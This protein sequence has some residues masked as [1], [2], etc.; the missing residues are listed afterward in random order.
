MNIFDFDRLDLAS[1]CEQ[2]FVLRGR[3]ITYRWYYKKI[4]NLYDMGSF[5]AEVTYSPEDNNI[6]WV[7]GIP[8]ND[9]RVDAYINSEILNS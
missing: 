5:F 6:T 8:L 2:V 1:K 4:L 9:K 3:F 7:E